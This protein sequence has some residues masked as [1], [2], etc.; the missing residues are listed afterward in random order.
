MIVYSYTD[1]TLHEYKIFR[2]SLFQEYK[3]VY[4][5]KEVEI[6]NLQTKEKSKEKLSNLED[7]SIVRNMGAM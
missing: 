4:P 5:N 6:I 3:R 1:Q 7:W 2:E